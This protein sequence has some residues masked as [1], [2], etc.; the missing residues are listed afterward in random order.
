MTK[1]ASRDSLRHQRGR[2]RD[3]KK[4]PFE[5][6]YVALLEA[7]R[8]ADKNQRLAILKNA[9]SKLI[10]YICECALN[11][12]KGVVALKDCQKKKLKKFKNTLRKLASKGVKK[13][14][15]SSWKKKKRIL[16]QKGGSLIPL[17]LSPILDGI[18]STIFSR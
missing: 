13:S 9:D 18:F 17:L 11:V 15:K 8:H 6:K 14:R 2:Q 4:C 12:L 16:V 3:G 1:N 7:L 10:K 5:K